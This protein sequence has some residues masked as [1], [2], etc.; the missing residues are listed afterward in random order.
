VISDFDQIL[1]AIELDNYSNDR[2]LIEL[3]KRLA[4]SPGLFQFYTFDLT[5]FGN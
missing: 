3:L 1:K 4:L 2:P 5:E